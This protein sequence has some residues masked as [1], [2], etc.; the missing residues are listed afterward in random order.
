MMRPPPYLLLLL[1]LL[2]LPF[3][4]PAR[5]IA[6]ITFAEKITLADSPLILNGAGIRSKFFFDIYIGALYLPEKTHDAKTAINMPG[7]KRVVMYFLYKKVDREKLVDGWNE[8][9]ENNLSSR[10]FQAIKPQLTDFNKLFV[11][12]QR[13]DRITLDYRP[14]TGTQVS[15]N[16]TLKGRV[17]GD[18]FYAALLRVWLGEEPADTD[19]KTGMLGNE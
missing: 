3:S 7:A 19:L 9:F 6:G 16:G 15:I 4:T 10:A 17:G 13:G 1:L 8:G 14:D 2:C 12:V 18:K 11:N 5:E